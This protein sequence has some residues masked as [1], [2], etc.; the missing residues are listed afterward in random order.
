MMQPFTITSM[1]ISAACDHV[2]DRGVDY[3]ECYVVSAKFA[4][5]SSDR[6]MYDE[7]CKAYDSLSKEP[8][9]AVRE[10]I[11]DI[12]ENVNVLP[13]WSYLRTLATIYEHLY[14]C[15]CKDGTQCPECEVVVE[16]PNPH[17]IHLE[18]LEKWL[19]NKYEI[20]SDLEFSNGYGITTAKEALLAFQYLRE[21]QK[22]VLT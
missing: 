1:I 11:N 21:M 22:N 14:S 18:N 5:C 16:A 19:Q 7:A 2:A 4:R 20:D 6:K 3:L 9:A 13:T 17:E 12:V 8:L 15:K 10:V